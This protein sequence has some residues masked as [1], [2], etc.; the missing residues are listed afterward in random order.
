MRLRA[1]RHLRF[2]RL[3]AGRRV[4]GRDSHECRQFQRG[5]GRVARLSCCRDDWHLIP[6]VRAGF[7]VA[8]SSVDGWLYGP[9]VR[10]EKTSDWHGWDSLHAANWPSR[11]S[12]IAT[13]CPTTVRAAAPGIRSAARTRLAHPRTARSSSACTASS[14]WSLD[15]PTSPSREATKQSMQA[16]FGFTLQP[17]GRATISG[18]SMRRAS[19]SAT[20]WRASSPAWRIRHRQAVLIPRSGRDRRVSSRSARAAPRAR[21]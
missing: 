5:A 16:E 18:G 15:P 11:A 19:A 20:G 4:L 17:R 2:L 7:S 13:R 6:Y 3:Q 1:A 9:G 21:A 10:L 12:S 8:S 14:T